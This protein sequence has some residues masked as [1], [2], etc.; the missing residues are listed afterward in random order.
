MEA[1]IDTRRTIWTVEMSA[2]VVRTAA[3]ERIKYRAARAAHW[4]AERDALI[5]KIKKEGIDITSAFDQFSKTYSNTMKGGG[6]VRVTVDETMVRSLNEASGK[7]AEHE[8]ALGKF[9]KWERFLRAMPPNA[10]LKLTFDDYL[11]LCEDY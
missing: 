10:V 11:F 6:G 9:Q 3:A 5:E 8:N 1:N 4:A 7:V 2:E